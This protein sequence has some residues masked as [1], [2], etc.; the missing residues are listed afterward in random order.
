MTKFFSLKISEA[1]VWFKILFWGSIVCTPLIVIS[2]TSKMLMGVWTI[3]M[4]MWFVV[5]ALS[6]FWCIWLLAQQKKIGWNLLIFV[7]IFS[8][9]INTIVNPSHWWVFL[10]SGGCVYLYYLSLRHKGYWQKLC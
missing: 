9:I 8:A 2:Y 1:G 10:T 3:P 6:G 5:C 7:T 4:G